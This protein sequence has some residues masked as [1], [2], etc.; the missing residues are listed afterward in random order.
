MLDYVDPESGKKHTRFHEVE[1]VKINL[2]DGKVQLEGK[3]ETTAITIGEGVRTGVI[4][5]ETVGYFMA[6]IQLFMLRLGLDP[7][8]IR[9]R[10]HMENE[11]GE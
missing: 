11:M 7:A 1:D 10:E 4:D 9:F 5:N 8:K 6:R 3:T 2:L